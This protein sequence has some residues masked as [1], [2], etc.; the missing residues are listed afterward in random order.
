MKLYE[1]MEK[2][3]NIGWCKPVVSDDGAAAVAEQEGRAVAVRISGVDYTGG[4][5]PA[6]LERAARRVNP[7][8]DMYHGY[9]DLHIYL[10]GDTHETGCACCPWRDECDAMDTDD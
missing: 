7:D 6:A 8:Y 5:I 3:E 4:A 2:T 10:D 9:D 1:K